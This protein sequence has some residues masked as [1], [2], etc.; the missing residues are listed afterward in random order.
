MTQPSKLCFLLMRGFC[1]GIHQ[2]FSININLFPLPW[3]IFQGEHIFDLPKKKSWHGLFWLWENCE[4][5][6][7]GDL[8]QGIH[9]QQAFGE[10]FK[11]IQ[12]NLTPNSIP[13]TCA[14]YTVVLNRCCW[15]QSTELKGRLRHLLR[16]EGK[17]YQINCFSR[18]R[19][20]FFI[21]SFWQCTPLPYSRFSYSLLHWI[22]SQRGQSPI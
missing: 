17:T 6:S 13:C 8:P 22:P 1:L 5:G 19:T 20:E 21:C 15:P 11:P 16:L 4:L 10:R 2:D 9:Y 18:E 14:T 3:N 7:I 12:P